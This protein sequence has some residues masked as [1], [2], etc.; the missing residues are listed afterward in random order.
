M[1][2]GGYVI[3]LNTPLQMTIAISAGMGLS[4]LH[5]KYVTMWQTLLF[6][7]PA[8]A[9]IRLISA[10]LIPQTM[11]NVRLVEILKLAI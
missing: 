2:Q 1:R 5:L 3:R 11:L 7:K 10:L 9:L 6:A 4:R 8:Q